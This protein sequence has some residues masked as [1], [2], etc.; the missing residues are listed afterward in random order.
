MGKHEPMT[1]RIWKSKLVFEGWLAFIKWDTVY[2]LLNNP[3]EAI[4]HTW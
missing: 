4:N 3:V 1:T 2:L